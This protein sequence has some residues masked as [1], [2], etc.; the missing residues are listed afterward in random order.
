[1]S[2]LDD[3]Q[4]QAAAL[5]AQQ[6]QDSAALARNTAL[7]ET[8]C[9][10]ALDYFIRLAAQLDVLKPA[11]P[12]RF[13]LDRRHVFEG[14]T[15]RDF[16]VDSRRKTL[17][18]E[19]VCDHVVMHWR[20]A[21]GRTLQIEKDFLPD[22]EKIEARLRQGGARVDTETLRNPDNGHLLGMRYSVQADFIGTVRITPQHDAA[23]LHLRLDNLDGFET[24]VFELPAIEVGTP[25]LDEL[26]RWLT[27]HPHAFLQGTQ[28]LRRSEA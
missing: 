4:R 8:A 19:D 22:I 16:K 23:R 21:S 24:L 27:G 10:A 20:I 15:L 17:R 9:K 26:A 11:S 25:R 14:L 7:T 12:A 18:G 13:A 3:L 1:V 5:K 6:T 28:A 2:F